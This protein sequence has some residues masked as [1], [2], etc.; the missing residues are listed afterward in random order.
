VQVAAADARPD[1][2]LP[3]GAHEALV[4]V[5]YVNGRAGMHHQASIGSYRLITPPITQCRK[6]VPGQPLV[7]PW[8]Y[9]ETF[10]P[11]LQ[12]YL[13]MSREFRDSLTHIPRG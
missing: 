6:P 11:H 12:D 7:E 9:E 4:Y 3:A 8:G 10:R 13:E 2:S 1:L 5:W